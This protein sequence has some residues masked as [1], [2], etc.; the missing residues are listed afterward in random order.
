MFLCTQK[1][2]ANS[3]HVCVGS[4][5]DGVNHSPDQPARANGQ[6]ML[7]AKQQ[8]PTQKYRRV[9]GM[10]IQPM[11]KFELDNRQPV[12]VL[13]IRLHKEHNRACS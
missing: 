7:H 2:E 4:Y 11:V 10:S 3:Q 8:I 13:L 5:T 12:I 9:T 6:R 1:H